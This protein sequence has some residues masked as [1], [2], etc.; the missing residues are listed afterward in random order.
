MAA[1]LF[2]FFRQPILFACHIPSLCFVMVVTE[3]TFVTTTL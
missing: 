2:K 3:Q 1:I